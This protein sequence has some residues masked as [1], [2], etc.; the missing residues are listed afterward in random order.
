MAHPHFTKQQ[1][2]AINNKV[3]STQRQT[4]GFT[5][6]ESGNKETKCKARSPD[7]AVRDS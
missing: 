3:L 4:V 1:S 7:K 2:S 6:S 5:E